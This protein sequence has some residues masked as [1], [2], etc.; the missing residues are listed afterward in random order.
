MEDA[1]GAPRAAAGGRRAQ[2]A[3]GVLRRLRYLAARH[4]VLLVA[5][6]A[7]LATMAAVPPDGA[8]LGYLDL[9]TLGCLFG[10][11]AVVAA[12]RHLGVFERAAREVVDRFA[13]CRGAV[14]ALVGATLLLSMVA[15]NDMALLMMLPLAAATLL[16][17]G[18]ARALPVTFVLQNL[19]ANLGGMILPFGNPQNLYLYE[20]FAIPLGDFLATMALPFAVSVALIAACC[21]LLVPATRKEGTVAEGEVAEAE[22]AVAEGDATAAEAEGTVSEAEGAAAAAGAARPAEGAAVPACAAAPPEPSSRKAVGD[23]RTADARPAPPAPGGQAVPAILPSRRARAL[24]CLGLLALMVASVL[25]LVPWP[26]AVAAVVAV[27]AVLDRRALAQVDYG[28]LLTF[29][30]F[31]VFAG[32]MARIPAVVDALAPLMAGCG[33]WVSAGASQVI[34]NVPAAVLLSH[35]TSDWAPLLVGVNVGGAGTLVASLAGLITFSHYRS[36]RALFARSGPAALPRTRVF[37]GWFT[38]L[39]FAFL[40]VLL[41][42]SALALG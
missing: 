9:R 35:F 24:V 23:A 42:A 38:A 2:G 27:L 13:T 32:N 1:K 3:R 15:T 5:A 12:L 16:E 8:Y 30:C 31:F 18:W 4:A 41:A 6:A 17:A 21:A 14:A 25:R 33:L 37:L 10:I 39:G 19:A 20:R 22:G 7:A 34:S 40:A 36:V 29:T 26:A 28:L 11:L